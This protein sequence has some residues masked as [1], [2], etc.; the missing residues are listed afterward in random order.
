VISVLCKLYLEQVAGMQMRCRMARGLAVGL[1]ALLGS[2]RPSVG[3]NTLRPI[4]PEDYYSIS[5]PGDPQ[6]SPDGKTVAYVVTSMESKTKASND[7]WL[8]PMDASE[9][10]RQLTRSTDSSTSPRWS[11]D[12][13]SLAFLSARPM[14]ADDR[15][16][17]KQ[18]HLLMLDGGE[19]HP[20][21]SLPE[22]VDSFSWS[23]DGT[24]LVCISMTPAPDPDPDAGD[25]R[26]YIHS[27][28]KRDGAGFLTAARKHIWVAD[29]KSGTAKQITRGDDWDDLAPEWSPDGT[30]IAFV[31][32]RSRKAWEDSEDDFTS[33]WVVS[34]DGGEPTQVS[35][36]S[37][38]QHSG[39]HWSP[40][41]KY[42]AYLAAQLDND[43]YTLYLIPSQLG[44]A[45]RELVKQIGPGGGS[46]LQ[47]GDQG[48]ALYCVSKIDGTEQVY[49][50]DATSGAITK[51]T[52]GEH[53]I[54]SLTLSKTN[55]AMVYTLT[56]F[57]RAFEI[58][59]AQMDGTGDRALTDVN[60]A[61][62]QQVAVQPVERMPYKSKD[63]TAI[64]GFLV[65]P[66]GWQAGR[67]YP[68]VL[69][70][71]GGPEA[72]FA[73]R[74]MLP[75]QVL[76]AHGY[77]VLFA[78][79][80]GS[81]GY[82]RAFMRGAVKQ[83]GGNI[84]TDLMSGVDTAIAQNTWV[85]ADK[86]GVTGCSFGGFMTNWIV[87]QTARFK[88]AVPMCSIS[89]YISDEGARDAFYGHATDF[90]GDLYQNFD[91]YWKYSP[92][93]YA[94]N[95]KTPV[96]I[97][98]GE[99]DQRVP[100]E[101]AEEWFHSLHHFNVPSEMVIFPREAHDGLSTGEPKHVVAAM[102]WTSYWFARYIDG[103][104]NATAPDAIN[105]K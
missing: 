82:G 72:M 20:V 54:S 102:N 59:V 41:G 16:A 14:S 70:I 90:G 103:D 68:L 35:Q 23:P 3:Q 93:R 79:P 99:A 45:P 83:W 100:I 69:V 28:Y 10:P 4:R 37:G 33:V 95:V 38:A 49:R 92:L 55:D 89:D 25:E 12:G 22:G 21:T 65:K 75:M 39:A 98:H 73:T 84:Y 86:L 24:R 91:L 97:L 5:V 76:A 96:L 26:H 88:A 30:K 57:E 104:A 48:R 31:S 11:P 94:M 27:N 56:T 9:N 58:H 101:Q 53:G 64:D 105:K 1:I 60:H 71:H 47:W 7:I 18:V 6:V 80:R 87:T 13:K 51:L 8:V 85:D 34:A 61:F 42:L 66:V 74:W 67:K 44:Y 40:D 77:A 2:A 50:I 36:A 15:K 46:N 81:T 62:Y 63:G 32:D 78:N 52:A 17:K 43:P 19:A 29:I